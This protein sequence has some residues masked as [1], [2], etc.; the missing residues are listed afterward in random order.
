MPA[1]SLIFVLSQ[2]LLSSI[3]YYVA[4]QYDSRSPLVAA[5]SV[6]F[7]GAVLVV[8]LD[9]TVELFVAEVL[10]TLAYFVGLRAG[11]KSSVTA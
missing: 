4:R 9:H 2:A 10:I 8:V 7:V 11:S 6:F 3:V 5:I 1:V